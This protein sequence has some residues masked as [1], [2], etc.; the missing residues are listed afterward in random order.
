MD[1]EMKALLV[2]QHNR[3]MHDIKAEVLFPD[4]GMASSAEYVRNLFDAQNRI[5]LKL[6]NNGAE[7]A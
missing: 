4:S 5:F 7:N 3:L 2:E 1:K 6:I